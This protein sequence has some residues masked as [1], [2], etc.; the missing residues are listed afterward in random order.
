VVQDREAMDK[1]TGTCWGFTCT[2]TAG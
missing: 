2:G 1:F